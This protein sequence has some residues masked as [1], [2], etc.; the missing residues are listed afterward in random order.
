MELSV[1]TLAQRRRSVMK[2]GTIAHCGNFSDRAAA[3]L[4]D[5]TPAGTLNKARVTAW[6]CL[7]AAGTDYIVNLNRSDYVNEI[8]E[9]PAEK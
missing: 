3:H 9:K 6:L 5:M 8:V 4:A 2:C 1:A 7:T